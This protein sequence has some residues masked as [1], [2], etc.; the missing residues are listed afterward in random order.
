MANNSKILLILRVIQLTLP[1]AAAGWCFA[2]LT[3]NFNRIAIYELG[4]AAVV[5][6]SMLGLYQFLSPFQVIY[7]RIADRVPIFGYHRTPYIIMGMTLSACA[8]A[9]LPYIVIQMSQTPDQFYSLSFP[10]ISYIVGFMMLV[11]F[12]VGFAM[13]GANHLALVAETIEPRLR[14]IV[15]ASIWAVLI[16]GVI[17]SLS[18]IRRYM[19]DYDLDTMKSLYALSIPIVFL[20]TTIGVLGVEKRVKSR[21][22]RVQESEEKGEEHATLVEFIVAV[23]K[24]RAVRYFFLFIFLSNLGFSMQDNILEVFGAEVLEM[25]VGETGLFQQ[26]TGG[27]TI[28]GMF[29]MAALVFRGSVSKRIAITFGLVGIAFSFFA[30]GAGALNADPL[31]VNISLIVLGFCSGFMLVG[32][33]TAMM[34]FTT[35]TERGAFIGLWG[36]ALS[37]AMGSSSILGGQLVTSL[38]ESGR[39][40]AANG[41]AFIF[42]L[43]GIIVLI[44]VYYLWKVE[45]KTLDKK[46]DR[47]GMSKAMEADLS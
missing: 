29:L 22:E 31:M 16:I 41:F 42:S 9:T 28:V 15:T 12:G 30:L 45:H 6:T 11:I 10:Y 46:I 19:P 18:F 34:E 26:I 5:I 27:G 24:N 25:T 1:R 13:A 3:S 35:D 47:Q 32:T 17:L 44:S 21:N 37:I 39:M 33:L 40:A 4:I 14:G 7:G 8:I 2:I 36:L 20:V 38:I 43:E 23:F